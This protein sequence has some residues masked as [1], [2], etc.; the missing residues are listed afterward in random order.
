MVSEEGDDG[1]G[2][3]RGAGEGGGGSDGAWRSASM[4]AF[5]PG[6]QPPASVY[7]CGSTSV[8]T[9]PPWRM[10]SPL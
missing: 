6:A 3:G 1:G 4:R 7:A 9:W 5:M 8:P 10:S 2:R